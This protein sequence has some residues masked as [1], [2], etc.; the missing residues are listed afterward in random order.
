MSEPIDSDILDYD[1]EGGFGRWVL[2]LLR[3]CGAAF[4]ILLLTWSSLARPFRIP[5]GSMIPT[6]EIGDHIVVN[7]LGYGL[8]IPWYDPNSSGFLTLLPLSSRKIITWAEPARGDVIVFRY[9][10]D[11]EVDYIKRVV[12]LPG[13]TIEVRGG[14]L[15]LNGEQAPRS[16]V[17]ETQFVDNSCLP[18]PAKRYTEILAGISHPVLAS[19]YT[20]LGEFGPY[21]VPEGQYFVMGDNRDNSADS[22]VWGTVPEENI[23]GRASRIWLSWNTCQG[24]IPQIGSFRT[25]RI[26]KR[27]E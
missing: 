5:S 1:E 10:P 19:P 12:G 9:P 11:P 13:D 2:T 17:E 7:M 6:L 25:E 24:D 3:I 20:R 8:H 21:V 14:E 23:V 26:G 4:V 16:F 27:I 22:R 15:W 18:T